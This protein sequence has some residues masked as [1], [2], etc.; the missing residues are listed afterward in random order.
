[1]FKT[2]ILNLNPKFQLEQFNR[3]LNLLEEDKDRFAMDVQMICEMQGDMLKVVE[4]M[5]KQM[6]I[7]AYVEGGEHELKQK[8]THSVD[9]RRFSMLQLLSNANAQY[10]EVEDALQEAN[11][12]LSALRQSKSLTD[13]AGSDGDSSVNVLDQIRSILQKQLESINWADNEIGLLL[14]IFLNSFLLV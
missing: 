5:E 9:E 14:K 2:K 1:M 7:P 13:A 10:N 12:Q 8:Y 11:E 3:E 4:E 6:G